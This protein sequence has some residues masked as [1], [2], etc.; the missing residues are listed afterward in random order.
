[1]K[2]FH[3]V[4]ET[5]NVFISYSHDS[6]AHKADVL[7]LA[8]RLRT[9]GIRA[10]IDQYETDPEG[11][12]PHWMYAQIKSAS[13]TLVVCTEIYTSR[14]Q[15]PTG[16][17]GKGSRWEGAVITLE[18]YQSLMQSKKFI[19][20]LLQ[21]GPDDWIP[22]LLRGAT[23]YR[24]YNDDDYQRLYGRLQNI[25]PVEPPPVGKLRPPRVVNEGEDYRTYVLPTWDPSSKGLGNRREE[26]TNLPEESTDF[27]GRAEDLTRTRENIKQ[28]QTVTLTAPAGTGKTRLALAAASTFLGKFRD[29][30]WWIELASLN[31]GRD[32]SHA[33]AQ[34]LGVFDQPEQAAVAPIVQMLRRAEMLLV[35]DNCER[36]TVDVASLI[37][38]INRHCPGVRIVATSRET[39]GGEYEHTQ[40]VTPLTAPAPDRATPQTI[41]TSDAGALFIARAKAASDFRLS[42]LAEARAVSQICA[43]AQGVPLA[44]ELAAGA[45]SP[46]RVTKI[47]DEISQEIE[48]HGA[49]QRDRAL[50]VIIAWAYRQLSDNERVLWQRLSV[51]DG[52]FDPEA[53]AG[54]CL[55]DSFP[56][57]DLPRTLDRLLRQSFVAEA[58]RLSTQ[59]T[60][61]PGRFRLLE[62][63][64]HFGRKQL[65]SAHTMPD[66]KIR[67]AR[68]YLA[69]AETARP[70][71]RQSDQEHWLRVLEAD[72]ENLKSALHWS[73][74]VGDVESA[75]RLAG[76]LGRFWHMRGYWTEGRTLLREVL[77]L[78]DAGNFPSARA[79]AMVAKGHLAFVQADYPSAKRYYDEALELRREIGIEKD[80]ADSMHRV[81]CVDE[82]LGDREGARELQQAAMD[83]SEQTGNHELQADA[84]HHLGVLSGDLGDHT[85][86]GAYLERSLALRRSLRDRWGEGW[87]LVVLGSH[88]RFLGQTDRAKTCYRE[89][90][91]LFEAQADRRRI[92]SV[93]FLLADIASTEHAFKAANEKL[94][95]ASQIVSDIGDLRGQAE[96]LEGWAVLAAAQGQVERSFTLKGA[97]DALREHLNAPRSP[98]SERW[99]DKCLR[100]AESSEDWPKRFYWAGSGQRLAPSAALQFALTSTPA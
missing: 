15:D 12:W 39:L 82:V 23:S 79:G 13:F 10:H 59:R 70:R 49:S 22:D 57:D 81:G 36:F 93:L 34:A 31:N 75:L 73:K 4:V 47:A 77:D 98:S 26:H 56:P 85:A 48:M 17:I 90:Q 53:I 74:T 87:S 64:R 46:L 55:A 54:I 67:H 91:K 92:A 99:L 76:A 32:I 94:M 41:A 40:A 50:D 88:H 1:M 38:R 71:L 11:G 61:E 62:S 42:S 66:L 14:F 95:R 18:L 97:S 68:Y 43:L 33:L 60:Q 9:D 78:K 84:L 2:H 86:A 28:Y 83:L 51:F 24:V 80:I 100:A 44:I 89:S 35:F 19:P 29:G 7:A 30:V 96:A 37:D 8:H 25:K 27:I 16:S 72:H 45:T 5:P 52:G 20:I 21:N 69:L 58:K 6:E 65:A 3:V 63:L